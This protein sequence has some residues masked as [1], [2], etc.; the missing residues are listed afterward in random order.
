MKSGLGASAHTWSH[1]HRLCACLPP[2][3]LSPVPPHPS[4]PHPGTAATVSAGGH[5]GGCPRPWLAVPRHPPSRIQ[6]PKV[7]SFGGCRSPRSGGRPVG[8]GDGFLAPGR[9]T[10]FS[11]HLGPREVYSWPWVAWTAQR[12]HDLIH[13][14]L[15]SPAGVDGPPGP[16]CLTSGYQLGMETTRL[17]PQAQPPLGATTHGS[18]RA[19]RRFPEHMTNELP[20]L[21]RAGL[22]RL[23][24]AL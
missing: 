11:F 9:S 23:G 6:A 17:V 16:P 8:R 19:K 13:C 3:A 24:K 20:L 12:S 1:P 4:C 7:A 10:T 15:L 18:P 21:G 22:V 14:S 2:S 5:G